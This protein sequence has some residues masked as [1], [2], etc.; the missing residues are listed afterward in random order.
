MFLQFCRQSS[1]G[2]DNIAAVVEPE[3]APGR[4]PGGHPVWVRLPPAA[5][6]DECMRNYRESK[7]AGLIPASRESGC[8]SIQSVDQNVSQSLVVGQKF[9]RRE[10]G[11]NYMSRVRPPPAPFDGAVA[12]VVER[13]PTMIVAP[14]FEK[15]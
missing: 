7:D 11:R 1:P 8:S 15:V 5:L 13:V 3:D 12:Q 6:I 14:G 4:E 10:C 2:R 9:P